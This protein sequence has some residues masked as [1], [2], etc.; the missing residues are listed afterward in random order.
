MP[1]FCNLESAMYDG[2]GKYR[3]PEIKPVYELPINKWIGYNY[4]KKYGT[5]K[6]ISTG[7][8]FFIYDYHFECVWNAPDK[9]LTYLSRYGCVLSPDFSIF[10]DF[11]LAVNIFNH[12]RKHWLAAYWQSKG[13]TVIPSICWSDESSFEW[14]FDGEPVGGIVAVSDVGCRKNE[15]TQEGFKR[16]YNEMLKRLNPSKI[17]LYTGVI[18]NDYPGNVICVKRAN[19]LTSVEGGDS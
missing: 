1:K 9:Y 6:D 16:G 7:V 17:L 18:K 19:G 2:V 12:Y 15:A 14:C 5:Q 3:I 8:H 4:V 13:I 11:P 10:P